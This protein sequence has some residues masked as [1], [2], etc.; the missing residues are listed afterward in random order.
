[1]SHFFRSLPFQPYSYTLYPDGQAVG[2]YTP[3]NEFIWTRAMQV[4][5]EKFL[6]TRIPENRTDPRPKN[7]VHPECTLNG[8]KVCD[9]D[10]RKEL[11][12]DKT[13]LSEAIVKRLNPRS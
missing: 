1:M 4:T 13:S 2:K 8:T 9:I 11:R 12:G 10:I 5:K 3:K 6:D 7:I